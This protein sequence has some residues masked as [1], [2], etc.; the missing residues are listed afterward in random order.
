MSA[1][2]LAALSFAVLALRGWIIARVHIVAVKPLSSI[3]PFVRAFGCR[4]FSGNRTGAFLA[5]EGLM[6]AK[7]CKHGAFVLLIF[8]FSQ[9]ISCILRTNSVDFLGSFRILL[10]SLTLKNGETAGNRCV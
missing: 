5:Q 6:G 4:L 8:G 9:K 1:D 2:L 10:Y 3:K 7:K